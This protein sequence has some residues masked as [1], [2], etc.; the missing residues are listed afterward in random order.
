MPRITEVQPKSE[1]KVTIELTYN[2]F[3]TNYFTTAANASGGSSGS[4][5]ITIDGAVVALQAGPERLSLPPLPMRRSDIKGLGGVSTGATDFFLP[6][7]RVQRALKCL[8]CSLP[9]TRGT[10]QTSW[11]LRPFDECE[12]LGLQPAHESKMRALFP[13]AI[14]LL[15]AE[16]VLPQGP[17]Y[18]K[19][20]EGDMLLKV[21]GEYINRFIRLEEILDDSVG[22]EVR[23]LLQRGSDEC[24]ILIS[25]GDKHAITP[26]RYVQVCGA[27]FNTLSYQLA[28]VYN[29]PVKGVYV[30]EQ[31]GTLNPNVISR[32]LG[33]FRL[34]GEGGSILES[35]AHQPVPNLEAFIEVMKTLPDKAR[36]TVTARDIRDTHILQTHVV[37]L[38][39]HWSSEFKL[40]IRN[41]K[42]GLWD[43][44]D[45]GPAPPP[46]EITPKTARF[47]ELS[48]ATGPAVELIRSFVRVS[49]YMPVRVWPMRLTS[50]GLRLFRLMDFRGVEGPGMR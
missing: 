4:P 26:D 38:E 44:T 14:G 27:R 24:D 30:C 5:V 28:R 39:R 7:D 47:L 13:D 32:A 34:D 45:L 49:Y 50:R 48:P 42:T 35:I 3:N 11:S 43:A 6:L 41:D 46:R 19:V 29:V 12:R 17:S 9:I 25:V 21:N 33:S 22:G 18:G 36:V 23:L 2:D 10:I 15:V 37:Q 16:T 31:A 20:E 40:W 1:P 8:Q